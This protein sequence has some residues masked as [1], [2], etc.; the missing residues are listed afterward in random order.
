M[1]WERLQAV[2]FSFLTLADSGA[3]LTHAPAKLSETLAIIRPFRWERSPSLT[4]NS[5]STQVHMST[6]TVAH[7]ISYPCSS[8]SKEPSKTHK[9]RLVTVL[10]SL[11]AT[12][13]IGDMYSA[14]LTSLLARPARERPIGTLQA[15][16]EAMRDRGYELVV[17]RHSSSLTI[18]ETQGESTKGLEPVSLRMLR[19]A[20]CL[21]GIGYLLAAVALA[22]EIQIYRRSKK[23]MQT[24][25]TS[26][27][28]K[29]SPGDIFRKAIKNIGRVCRKA[30]RSLCRQIDR[31][32]G[33][34]LH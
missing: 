20:F 30:V 10:V 1:T 27:E 21:L 34:G 13:V 12:Y 7:P 4:E 8:S 9:A 2:E 15:L 22:V 3:F 33:P 24:E 18:L 23:C 17:E 31:A 28:H 6:L 25:M 14:N 5:P 11:G 32:L 26:S 16:E 19:G 29:R